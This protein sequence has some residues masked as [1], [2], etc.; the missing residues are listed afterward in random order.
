MTWEHTFRS[1]T[2]AAAHAAIVEHSDPFA[3]QL[4]TLL[5]GLASI[6]VFRVALDQYAARPPVRPDVAVIAQ[7]LDAHT[8][9][10]ARATASSWE[11]SDRI[12]DALQDQ[13]PR[14][15]P[16]ESSSLGR[17]LRFGRL[18]GALALLRASGDI[19]ADAAKATIVANEGSSP[20][21]EGIWTRLSARPDNS[22]L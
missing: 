6:I 14:E 5:S 3:A 2:A 4:L 13:I 17:S 10:V 22:H 11:L 7:L 1:G 12:L 18:V 9:Q 15:T 20:Q 19:D 16:H 21:I 8:A